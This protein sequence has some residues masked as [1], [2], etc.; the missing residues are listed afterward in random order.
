MDYDFQKEEDVK[1]FLEKLGVEYRFSCFSEKRPD[2][3]HLL[4]E[5]FETIKT[6]YEKAMKV[7]KNNCDEYKFAR[8]CNQYAT[9]ALRGRGS[10]QAREE[11]PK[12][13]EKGCN[14]G[15]SQACTT[16]GILALMN[17]NKKEANNKPSHIQ[18]AKNGME[19]LLRGCD[20]NN[21]HACYYASAVY[22]TGREEYNIP[23]DMEKAFKYAD[24]GCELGSIHAC[25][26][27]SMM[28]KKGDGVAKDLTKAK[29][30]ETKALEM[31]EQFREQIAMQRESK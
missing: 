7:F 3:C 15:S 28:Y 1:E 5:Y 20:L 6:D 18:N 9:M 19:M 11:A 22:I 26:N 25:G 24:R 2:S 13:Y 31:Q 10:K 17:A 29:F 4:G 14:F 30:F 16:G 21:Q 27:L 23:S 12:Y 8:S